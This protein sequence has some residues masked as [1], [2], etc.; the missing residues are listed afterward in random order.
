MNER[1]YEF[2]L[3]KKEY[4]YEF[5]SISP[6][7]EV[8]KVVL[9]TQTQY[10]NIY[11]LALLDTLEN[12]TLSD[13]TVTNNDDFK[14]VLATVIRIINSFLN[15]NPNSFVIFKGSDSRRHRLY[16]IIISRELEEIEKSFKVLAIKNNEII[17]FSSEI[18]MDFYLI[19]KHENN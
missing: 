17:S 14:T 11:N 7:K 15:E 2:S 3:V 12:G 8:Q 6:L 4:R 1:P 18:E 13:I 10:P 5:L 19:G 16:R 9:L